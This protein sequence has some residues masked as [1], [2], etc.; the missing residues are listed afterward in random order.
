MMYVAGYQAAR[1]EHRCRGHSCVLWSDGCA[2]VSH[3]CC[4][5]LRT[6]YGAFWLYLTRF[7]D[8]IHVLGL[9]FGSWG[10][11]WRD[12]DGLEMQVTAGFSG[13]SITPSIDQGDWRV[14][15]G[16]G[17]KSVQ[18]RPWG[19][20]SEGWDLGGLRGRCLRHYSCAGCNG[21]LVGWMNWLC[22]GSWAWGGRCGER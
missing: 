3:I 12:H 6:Q 1:G 16:L 17:G 4:G 2:A 18:L 22:W 5:M 21:W 10:E 11:S 8:I 14:G 7:F 19:G 9:C 15:S 20:Q 13:E